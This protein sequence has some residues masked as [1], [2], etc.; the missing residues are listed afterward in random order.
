MTTEI[1]FNSSLCLKYVLNDGCKEKHV[2][3]YQLGVEKYK[4][5]EL[6]VQHQ[7]IIWTEYW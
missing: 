1:V 4:L 6:V 3:A 7:T 2:D 5:V